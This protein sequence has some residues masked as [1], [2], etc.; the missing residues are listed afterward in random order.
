MN[1]V[2]VGCGRHGAELASRLSNKG[3]T[4]V[5][6]ERNEEEFRNLPA[7]FRGRMVAGEPLD[8]DVLHR[9]GMEQ[10]DGFAAVTRSDALNVVLCHIARS[11]Y[12]IPHV[13]AR[14]FHPRWRPVHETF[15]LQVVSSTDWGVQRIEELLYHQEMRSVFSAGNG[16]IEV[17]EIIINDLWHGRPIRDLLPGGDVI[18]I[19]LTR[20]GR[21]ELPDE[22]MTLEK[23]DILHVSATMEGIESIRHRLTPAASAASAAKERK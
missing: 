10:A 9:A 8:R 7:D 1:V 11:V 22:D 5:V 16:E 19:A 2:I 6:V 17:Y 13:V 23:D 4:V 15:N 12:N 14:N 21:A 18:A 3:H 20:G